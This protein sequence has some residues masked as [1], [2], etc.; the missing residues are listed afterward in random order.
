[1]DAFGM[2][3]EVLGSISEAALA[4]AI[5]AGRGVLRR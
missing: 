4:L 2:L 5:L 3:D 1:M